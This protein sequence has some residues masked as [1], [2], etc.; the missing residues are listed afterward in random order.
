MHRNYSYKYSATDGRDETGYQRYS[1]EK[2]ALPCI[3]EK[4]GKND[5]FVKTRLLMYLGMVPAFATAHTFCAYRN[6]PRN[7]NFFL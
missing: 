7:S 1:V 3:L 2:S 5:F 4:I 6:G